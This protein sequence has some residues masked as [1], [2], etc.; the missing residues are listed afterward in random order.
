MKCESCGG[1]V[2]ERRLDS[3]QFTESGLDDVSLVGVLE[4]RCEAC[5]DREVVLPR[6]KEL[7]RVIAKA[8]AAKSSLLTPQEFRFLRKHLGFSQGDFA[9]RVNIRAEAVS[10]W[11]TGA[12][13]ISWHFELLLRLMVLLELHERSYSVKSFD[14]VDAKRRPAHVRIF[15]DKTAWRH[16]GT[17]MLAATC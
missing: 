2:V 14:A 11:E 1:A 16:E 13:E 15:S 17:G 4:R 10:R 12:E 9:E 8:L 6:L 5:G 3:Y 7:H